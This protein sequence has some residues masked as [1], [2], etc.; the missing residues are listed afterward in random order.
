MSGSPT[1]TVTPVRAHLLEMSGDA[2][3]ALASYQT[4]AHY[5]TSIPEQRYLLARV[6]RLRTQH[7]KP[8]TS[9]GST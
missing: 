3:A 6:A 2:D 9:A 1:S 4:A 8:H 7:P 5:T